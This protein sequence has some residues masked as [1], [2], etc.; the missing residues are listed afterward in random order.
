[1]FFINQ[2]GMGFQPMSH[3]QDADATTNFFRFGRF[4]KNF[5]SPRERPLA[6][7]KRRLSIEACSESL[8]PT[9][10]DR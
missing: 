5:F 7:A 8:P 10:I 1:M 9:I 6:R 2:C 3:R 4:S